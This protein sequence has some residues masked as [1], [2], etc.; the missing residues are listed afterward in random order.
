[1]PSAPGVLASRKNPRLKRYDGH[2]C[3]FLEAIS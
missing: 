1:M 2:A 3:V